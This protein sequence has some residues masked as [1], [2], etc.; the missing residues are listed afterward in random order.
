M[1]SNPV[2]SSDS[3]SSPGALTV[4]LVAAWLGLLTGI[5]EVALLGIRRYVLHHFLFVGQDIVWAVPVADAVLFVIL[6]VLFLVLHRIAPARVRLV[7]LVGLLT[8]VGCFA[9][10][11]HYGPLHRGA[12]LLLAVGAGVQVARMWN[13]ASPRLLTLVRRTMPVLLGLVILVAGVQAGAHWWK[14][15][16]AATMTARAGEAPV[17]VLLIVLD[18]V[19]AWSMSAYGYSRATTPALAHWAE[20]GV[21]FSRAFSTAPWTLPSH[22]SMF[23]GRWP[24]QLS[25]DWLVPLDR[26]TPVLAEYFR[27]RGY[28]TAG[29]VGNTL[30]CSYETG[31]SRGFQQYQDYLVTPGALLLSSSLAKFFMDDRDLWHR[32]KRKNAAQIDGDFLEWLDR[33]P[34][35]VPFFAFLNYFDAHD[36]YQPPAPYDTWFDST[37]RTEYLRVVR[38][39][40]PARQ[41]PS[42]AVT[43]ARNQYDGALAYLDNQLSQLFD[44][45]ARRDLTRN[46]LVIVVSDHGEEFGEHGIY[47]HGN[48][49][50]RAS[51]QVPLM[52]VLP[53]KVPAGQVVDH[54]VSLRD[55]A[56]T[57]V[58][59][60]GAQE[61]PFPGKSLDRFWGAERGTQPSDSLL[62]ELNYTARLPANTPISRGPM[63]SLILDGSRLIRNGD[64]VNELYDF[65]SD[66]LE[67]R[68]LAADSSGAVTLVKLN[69]ALGALL[70]VSN[71]GTSQASPGPQSRAG[72]P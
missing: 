24:H 63:K 71:S 54:P 55:L 50:Y 62:S 18:T 35:G 19:R 26:K 39:A 67:A 47:F 51:I 17:N 16:Q 42:V 65:E 12:A 41:W 27:N 34:Q 10:F 32:L 9:W 66:T 45:L 52:L 46:T 21:R 33:R 20:G 64:G 30:Y 43:G 3:R 28:L 61:S 49:L 37:G 7:H 53:G 13:R 31:L 22:A 68:N 58:S 56:A 48:S 44:A 60:T 57:I 38:A 14:R 25:A 40:T 4:L 1:Q 11:L 8:A 72:R 70:K 2:T 29:F 23:T 69:E 15:R 5:G 6:A 36:P 59:L